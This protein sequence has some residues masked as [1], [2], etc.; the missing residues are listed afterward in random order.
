[1]IPSLVEY[2]TFKNISFH[3]TYMHE[4][5]EY[6]VD[7]VT[8]LEIN[9]IIP[10]VSVTKTLSKTTIYNG[11]IVNVDYSIKN[12]DENTIYDLVLYL[13][14]D[15][16]FDSLENVF[17]Y[18]IDKLDPGETTDKILS[19]PVVPRYC[20]IEDAIDEES[21]PPDNVTATGTSLL[22]RNLTESLNNSLT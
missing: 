19:W 5:K 8:T 12:N 15:Q 3:A 22:I 1:M 2:K 4:N 11:E 13:T 16:N 14:K 20:F 9:P 10:E 6:N 7:S 17:E 21:K 18:K